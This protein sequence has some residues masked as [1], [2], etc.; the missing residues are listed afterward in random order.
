MLD[1]IFWHMNLN[2]QQGVIKVDMFGDDVY[3][4]DSFRQNT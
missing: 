3:L 2:S 4:V 1:S